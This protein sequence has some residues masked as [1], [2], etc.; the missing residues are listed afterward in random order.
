MWHAIEGAGYFPSDLAGTSTGVFVG[1]FTAD[2]NELLIES[3]DI[4]EAHAITGLAHSILPNRV[5]HLLDLHGPSVPV[6]TACSSSLVALHQAIESIQGGSCDMASL[7]GERS[8]LSDAIHVC[9]SGWMIC[10]DGRCKTFDKRADGY[11]RG[12]GVGA[13]L[14][15]PLSKALEDR[16]Q[17]CALVKGTAINHGVASNSLTSP[18]P[19]TQAEVILAAMERQGSLPR[20]SIISRRT[21]RVRASEIP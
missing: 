21:E 10:D 18:N 13:I 6:D 16:D 17:I 9:Q 15:K 3:G 7:A 19:E 20:A 2:Y 8:C 11:A 1:I 14:I 5:S 4:K 12:E